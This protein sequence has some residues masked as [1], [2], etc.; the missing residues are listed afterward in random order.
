[1]CSSMQSLPDNAFRR[2]K[3]L[4][5]ETA[6]SLLPKTTWRDLFADRPERSFNQH[7][8]NSL[9]TP[10]IR[11]STPPHP[12]A[13]RRF[14]SNQNESSHDLSHDAVQYFSAMLI[15]RIEN[16]WKDL[17]IPIADRKYYRENLFPYARQSFDRCRDLSVY[18][19]A[20][21]EHRRLIIEAM[22]AI[23]SRQYIKKQLEINLSMHRAQLNH[24]H[25]VETSLKPMNYMSYHAKEELLNLL[26]ELQSSTVNVVVCIQTWRR[27]C[28]RPQSF[29][30]CH[31]NYFE[32]ILR[33]GHSM[34]QNELLL[35]LL[36]QTPFSQQHFPLV[37]I[38]ERIPFNQYLSTMDQYHADD[39]KFSE[40]YSTSVDKD[41]TCS[42]LKV[43]LEENRLQKAFKTEA[44]ALT[45]Q[46]VFIPY[47]RAP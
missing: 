12:S 30:V 35:N 20:L 33:D 26:L 41:A 1:M 10:I 13:V 18:L 14:Y 11:T 38:D 23:S 46:G 25:I 21:Q 45:A 2:V 16:M 9:E 22:T 29:Q 44:D 27:S 24:M 39:D 36:S 3:R 17:N 37:F 8:I 28:W 15:K 31:S 32:T 42:A 5:T 6:T 40:M 7:V 43:V 4:Q 19:S 47:L 34:R